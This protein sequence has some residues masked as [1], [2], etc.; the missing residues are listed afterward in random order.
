MRTT[1]C[2]LFNLDNKIPQLKKTYNTALVAQADLFR[3]IYLG[4]QGKNPIVQFDVVFA[5]KG[6]RATANAKKSQ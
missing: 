5:S 1:I 6:D 3:T 2:D 4:M